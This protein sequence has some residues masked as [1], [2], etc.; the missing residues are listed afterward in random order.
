MDGL[1]MPAYTVTLLT[2]WVQFQTI[3]TVPDTCAAWANRKH[4]E[5][6]LAVVELTAEEYEKLTEVPWCNL[7]I[8]QLCVSAEDVSF[9]AYTFEDRAIYMTLDLAG[10]LEEQN[11]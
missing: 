11:G 2:T 4:A 1:D 6:S 10:G 7:L 5:D 8:V 3:K 9:E